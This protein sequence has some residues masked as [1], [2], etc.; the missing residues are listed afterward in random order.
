MLL[1]ACEKI[2]NFVNDICIVYIAVKVTVML[3]VILNCQT[4]FYWQMSHFTL[5]IIILCYKQK[6]S[7]F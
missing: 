3:T 6:F 7:T 4:Q 2:V 1:R 5:L